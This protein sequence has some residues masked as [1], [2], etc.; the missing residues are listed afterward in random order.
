MLSK[1]DQLVAG[2]GL[3]RRGGFHPDTDDGAPALPSGVSTKTIVL[4]GNVGGEMWPHFAASPEHAESG[5]HRLDR[6][7]QRVLTGIAL[8][9]GAEAL[10]PFGGP[11]YLP[12]QRWAMKAEPV[13]ASP[14][15]ILIHP[16]FGLWHAYRGALAFAERLD[17]PARPE[18]AKPCD[19]CADQP[20]LKACPVGAFG[21][22]KYDVAACAGH[23]A[24]PN[25][26]VCMTGSC[27]ARRVCP[28]G[29]SHAYN[30]D[31]SAFHMQAFVAARVT[32]L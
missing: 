7:T 9:V 31:Q 2:H 6:W 23:L 15:G 30:P 32:V 25:G 14:L 29:R 19:S 4:V 17:L 10:F 24:G 8:E 13:S 22:G 27:L 28:I 11:H 26:T 3:R 18:P 20:C 12:F 16:E 5:A 21:A 1:I